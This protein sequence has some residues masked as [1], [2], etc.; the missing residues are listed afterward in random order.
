[1][2]TELHYRRL[3]RI[4]LLFAGL[5]GLALVLVLALIY[6][7]L[8]AGEGDGI[9]YQV[10]ETDFRTRG[11]IFDNE[12][13]YLALDTPVYKLIAVPK[14]ITATETITGCLA[15]VQDLAAI[16]EISDPIKLVA[17]LDSTEPDESNEPDEP[18]KPVKQE[19][20]YLDALIPY[21]ISRQVKEL[22]RTGL[23]LEPSF[24]R[25]YPE[26]ELFGPVVGLTIWYSVTGGSGIEGYYKPELTGRDPKGWEGFSPLQEQL[27]E[28]MEGSEVD[29]AG[30]DPE[31]VLRIADLP[32]VREGA[33]LHT[34][35]DRNV[36]RIAYDALREGVILSGA[37]RGQIIVMEPSTGKVRA[38]V[39][40]PSFDPNRY[41]EYF[42]ERESYLKDHSVSSIY[43][44]GSVIKMMTVAAAIN[45]GLIN[46]STTFN[47]MGEITIGTETIYNWDKNAWGLVNTVEVLAYS[48]NVEAAAIAQMLQ[49]AVFYEYM[50]RFGFGESSRIDL[51][52]EAR[53]A[54]R[55]PGQ[56]DWN[57]SDLG[58]NSYGQG[59]S[60]TPM[61]VLTA[62]SVMANDGKRMRPYVVE[63]IV[64]DGEERIIKP[65]VACEEV[66]SPQTAREVSR[67]LAESIEI[68]IPK[69]R[70]PGYTIAGKSGT[71][72]K[73]IGGS[74]HPTRT[75][76]SFA[77][78]GPVE[79]PE[80]SILVTL[81]E[82]KTSSY[83]SVVAAPVFS[84]VARALFA[85]Y[86]IPPTSRR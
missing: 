49:P 63:R 50:R 52:E 54:L 65:Q 85:Y 25:Y 36:Q 68:N 56:S 61:L 80:F 16:V 75:I 71:S 58:T 35:L 60:A 44:P 86:G 23:E 42:P 70:V 3:R 81:D 40:Y 59:L 79:D 30:E 55:V 22:C 32:Q 19:R 45:E 24:I 18:D 21:E 1:M 31:R 28:V 11:S 46:A 8:L 29:V 53:G 82:P 78:F 67:I 34:T 69:A 17:Q 2:N 51:A 10:G 13:H 37:I 66:I 14:D 26:G 73:P 5:T 77:G 62:V 6:W 39:N 4:R 64:Q 41:P 33:D 12:G 27:L 7:Q 20:I 74:Y 9:L 72:E 76:A 57:M 15:L 84:R 43:E 83:G 48:L 38:V 47:D